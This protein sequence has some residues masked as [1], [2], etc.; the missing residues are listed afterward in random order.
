M[1]HLR[2]AGRAVGLPAL[3]LAACAALTTGA[4]PAA[5]DDGTVHYWITCQTATQYGNLHAQDPIRVLTYHMQ[6]GYNGNSSSGWSMVL[7]Y[8][9]P[10]PKWGYVLSSCIERDPRYP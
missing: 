2:T 6:V 3:A 1:R 8:P 5:A 10:D 7:R 4:S 9:A